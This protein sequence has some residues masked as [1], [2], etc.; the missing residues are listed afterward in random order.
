MKTNIILSVLL[1]IAITT[2]VFYITNN[3][4]L[5][6]DIKQ[7]E[8]EYANYKDSVL[9][10]Q[11]YLF[12]QIDSLTTAK[13][14]IIE[15]IKLIPTM[16]SEL[17]SLTDTA[18]IVKT[19]STY[20]YNTKD[21][22]KNDIRFI[23]LNRSIATDYILSVYSLHS[24]MSLSELQSN[25]I[26]KWTQLYDN[27]NKLRLHCEQLSSDYQSAFKQKDN[28]LK[29]YS[30]VAIGAGCGIMTSAFNEKLPTVLAMTGIGFGVSYLYQVIF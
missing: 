19:D 3:N 18:L 5:S 13:N 11:S 26:S 22:A 23:R 7:K 15:H 30:S 28:Q 10:V 12:N 29:L 24:Y 4:K 6:K 1:V 20:V 16:K 8:T 17:T 2:T 21:T 14:V 25:E 27:E 9:N